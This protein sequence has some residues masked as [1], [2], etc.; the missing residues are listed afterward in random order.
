M[1]ESLAAQRYRI[2][3]PRRCGEI[4]ARERLKVLH[5][6]RLAF[7]GMTSCVRR[8]DANPSSQQL[9]EHRRTEREHLTANDEN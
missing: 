5:P 6:Y 9:A 4:A 3:S 1:A 7:K 8:S 2:I